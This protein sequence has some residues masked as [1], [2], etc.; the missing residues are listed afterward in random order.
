[1]IHRDR[2]NRCQRRSVDHGGRIVAPAKP[3]FK[4]YNIGGRLREG[5]EGRGCGDLEISDLL[6]LVRGLANF[7]QIGQRVFLDQT[8]RQSNALVEPN[9]MR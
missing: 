1:M 6:T 2:G 5:L 7:K 9:E 4:Q 3:A 8:T